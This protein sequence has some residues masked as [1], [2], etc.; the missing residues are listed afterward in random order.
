MQ[1]YPI[2]PRP[3]TRAERVALRTGLPGFCPACGALTIFRGWTQDLRESGLCGRCGATNRQRQMA[4]LACAELSQRQGQRVRSL[5][6]VAAT[7]LAIYN[8]EAVGPVH[9]QLKRHP[10]Y[11]CSEYFG[12]GAAPGE[13]RGGVRHEDLQRLSFA[14]ASLDLVLSSDV[15]EHVPDPYRGFREVHRVLKPGG[16]HLFTVAFHVGEFQDDVRAVME[17]GRTT[18]LKD[19]WYH[20][21]PLRPE[22]V[23]VYTVPALEM[24]VKLDL[25][26]LRTAML[27]LYRPLNGILGYTSVVFVSTKT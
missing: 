23:L 18:L 27:Q 10:G 19:A 6:S 5:A 9:A 2:E 12:P 17:D 25:I 13:L 24:L 11:A 1:L 16:R 15:F 20:G 22:G 8:T 3:P 4:H 21:D 7:G 14:D 26:G